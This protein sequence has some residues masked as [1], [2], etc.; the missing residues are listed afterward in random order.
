MP[1]D[2]ITLGLLIVN[3]FEIKDAYPCVHSQSWMSILQ[4]DGSQKALTIVAI[5]V[6]AVSVA[7]GTVCYLGKV[8]NWK[9][10]VS[11]WSCRPNPDTGDEGCPYERR[12][13]AHR[14]TVSAPESVARKNSFE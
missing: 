1:P 8:Y 3:R 14:E 13:S 2:H 6:A 10:P 12:K 5:A 9:C 4:S 11:W 7:A